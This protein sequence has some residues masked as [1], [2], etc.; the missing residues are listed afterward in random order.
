MLPLVL[1]LIVPC[2][3][4]L[5]V[6]NV[7]QYKGGAAEI[8]R[9]DLLIDPKSDPSVSKVVQQLSSVALPSYLMKWMFKLSC[10]LEAVL[11]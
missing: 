3:A 10:V 9:F 2:F 5:P 11:L 6:V 1:W 7:R 8:F 4:Q